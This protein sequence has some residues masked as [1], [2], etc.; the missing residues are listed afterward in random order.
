MTTFS[1]I[2]PLKNTFTY[3]IFYLNPKS[4]FGPFWGPFLGAVLTNLQLQLGPFWP[5]WG[6]FDLIL[7][8]TILYYTILYYTI[9]YYTILYY[10]ILYYTILYYTILYYTILHYTILYYTVKTEY[11]ISVIIHCKTNTHVRIKYNIYDI[12][13]QTTNAYMLNIN[14]NVLTKWWHEKVN[15]SFQGYW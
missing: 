6:R 5:I 4:N 9:L 3:I 15:D 14:I 11:N 2:F 12:I 13:G 1:T 8:Y 7:Y 10:T